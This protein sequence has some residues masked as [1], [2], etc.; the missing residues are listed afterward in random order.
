MD[1]IC[2]Q[3]QARNASK[4]LK[5][6]ETPRKLITDRNKVN[7]VCLEKSSLKVLYTNADQL[8][9]Q[10][11]SELKYKIL[12]HK[13]MIVAVCEV[14]PKNKTA[15]STVEYNIPGYT[16]RHTNLDNEDGRG[17][18]IYT[19]CELNPSI[20]QI[21]S[22]FQESVQIEM[23]LKGGDYLSFSC[24]YRSPTQTEQTSQNCAKLNT[25]ITEIAQNKKYTHRCIVGDFNYKDIEWSRWSTRK[26]EAS[27]EEKFLRTLQDT[28]MFQHVS[29]P[30]RRRGTDEPS[31]LDLVITDEAMQISEIMHDSPLGKSDHDTLIFDF[32]CYAERS[33]PTESF[34]YF[35]GDYES[36]VKDLQ[37]SNWSNKIVES[38]ETLSVEDMWLRIKGKLQLLRDK[39]VPKYKLSNKPHWSSKGCVPLDSKT[40]IA[41]KE[42]EKSFKKWIK[43]VSQEEKA[44]NRMI[45]T[46]ARNKVKNLVRSAK[47]KYEK[48]IADKSKYNPK[49]FWAYTRRKLKTITGV[50][51]LLDNV[52]DSTSLKFAAIDKANILQKQFSS[53]FTNEP[54][55]ILPR[56]NQRTDA[57][58]PNLRINLDSVKE[59]LQMLNVN[60]SMGPDG[61]HPMLLKEL[62]ECLA[63]PLTVLFNMTLDQGV[64]PDDWKLGNIFPIYKK[65]PKKIAENYRPISLTSV[66]CKMLEKLIRSHVMKHLVDNKLLSPRQYGF[67]SGRSTTTQLLYFIDKCINMISEGNVVDTIYFDFAKA[68]DSVPHKRLLHKLRSYGIGGNVF[69]WIKGFL[70][71]RKQYVSVENVSSEMAN[72][73]SGVPQGTVLGPILFIIYI[74]D[75]LDEINS[76]G[77]LF[78]DDTKIFNCILNKEDAHRLQSDID[79]LENWSRTWLMNF[80]PD[81]CHVLTLGRFTDI[82]Y[83]HRYKVYDKEIEHVFA[84]DLGIYI[85]GEL[86]FDDHICTKVR[87]ANATVGLI[88]RSFSHLDG[89]TLKKLFTSLVRHH[90]D[91]GQCVWAPHLM[92]HIN[93]IE[94]VQ[95][96][97][98]K[99]V[100][101]Y[102]SMDYDERLKNLGLTTLRFRRLR[103]DLIE[104]YKHFNTHDKEALTG[105]S[106][107]P[108]ERPSRQHKHQVILP[109]AERRHGL[110]ENAF[111]GRI[112]KAWNGLPRDV[113]EAENVNCFKNALDNHLKD[114]PMKYNHR[115]ADELERR[116][117]PRI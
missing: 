117:D 10:K 21:K 87:I 11:L 81:K 63:Q 54:D 25:L 104:M 45:F 103:G 62:S 3:L 57:S 16:M 93:M 59:T 82:K 30:T 89:P 115:Y 64:L 71:E 92:K 19:K 84:E 58:I 20:S 50:S 109:A 56:I 17:V 65:G 105:P 100:N 46:K 102:A 99:L 1:P 52:D 88:R 41:L 34:N 15:K 75:L 114:H 31:L 106:F 48:E 40:R 113:V 5:R 22:Q 14:K 49:P 26:S 68:F 35:K 61:L 101:G 13:P 96:R 47:K 67:I 74:N 12:L 110:R 90:L 51:P 70:L 33:A 69:N 77:V 108:R 2:E 73:L 9:S 7:L 72:V 86:T 24:V 18:V 27:A 97:A 60:K 76:E 95:E 83:T 23:R 53:V 6:V 91:Y 85:D 43:A 79:K 29:E 39:Y 38:A 32:K 37:E 44:T 112:S 111:Y 55:G 4:M 8:T 78:A 94:R 116:S 98:T 36:M 42:K 66:L 107:K 28:F 80:H